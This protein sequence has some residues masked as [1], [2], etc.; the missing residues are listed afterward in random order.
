[1]SN[2]VIGNLRVNLGL[3][4]AAFATG[5]KQAQ[6]QLS[7]LTSSIKGFA[8]MAAGALTLGGVATAVDGAVR[9]VAEIGDVAEG[10]GITAEELQVFNRMALASGSS[11]DAMAKG[12]QEIAEQSI[13]AGSALSKLFQSNGLAMQG[14]ELNGV[15]KDFMTLLQNAKSPADQLA[16]ATSVLGKRVG[17]DLVEAMRGGAES[18]D[19]AMQAMVQSGNYHTNS[20]VARLQEIETRYNEVTASIATA[21]QGMV[22]DLI[23]SG[24]EFVEWI[25]QSNAELLKLSSAGE[26]EAKLEQAK[27]DLAN[28]KANLASGIDGRAKF[29]VEQ[30][31]K[32]LESLVRLYETAAARASE[33][34]SAPGKGDLQRPQSATP[35]PPETKFS[36]PTISP[37][38]VGNIREATAALDQLK[39]AAQRVWEE[40]R[41]PL[42]QYQLEIRRLNEM[43]QQG[44]IDHDTYLRAVKQLQDGFSSASSS[45]FATELDAMNSGARELSNTIGN[46]LGD[47]LSQMAFTAK[48]AGD[49][50][51]I[52]RAEGV[53]AL[54]QIAAELIRTAIIKAIEAIISMIAG[55]PPGMGGGGAGAGSFQGFYANGGTL[56]AGKWGIAGEAGPEIVHGPARITPM[57]DFQRRES[58]VENKTFHIDARGAQPGV[59]E[60]IR[61][62][63][64]AYDRQMPSRIHNMRRRGQI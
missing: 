11:T 4:T 50:F 47:A 7:G 20:E 25:S 63:L 27:A 37:E 2:A 56:G 33:F 30:E 54:K 28:A 19:K 48:D 34:S 49:A 51:D 3:D 35:L 62:A 14:R 32:R 64:E 23:Q 57:K 45:G 36:L 24:A 1:M 16:M 18:Y 26:I 8:A 55:V 17:R 43:L 38:N 41:T 6:A 29:A 58:Y 61:R 13:D 12:L 15:I 10:I 9:A 53:D 39:L 46:H 5:A 31:I 21:W 59:G 40:T 60:E 52:M 22:V 42:E 44:A